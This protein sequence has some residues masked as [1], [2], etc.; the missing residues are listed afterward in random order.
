M[1]Q[2]IP[3]EIPMW[4][5]DSGEWLWK[6]LSPRLTRVT[7]AMED[8]LTMLALNW[9]PAVTART[10]HKGRAVCI[11]AFKQYFV[12]NDHET[13]SALVKARVEACHKYNVPVGDIASLEIAGILAALENTM[14]TAFWMLFYVFS[15]PSILADL[16][17]EL[18]NILQ[19]TEKSLGE[20]FRTLD[21]TAMKG[22]CPLL[23]SIF[24]ETLR[25]RSCGVSVRVV[26]QDTLLNDKFAIEA[27]CMIQMPSRVV[28][29]DPAI[30]GPTVKDFDPRRFLRGTTKEP[31]EHKAPAAAFR[32]FGGGTTLCPGR[33]FASTE[34]LCIVAMF[35]LR[36]DIDP[37]CGDWR[38]PPPKNQNIVA[39]TEF[40][41]VD[42]EVD[43]RPR[44]GYEDGSWGFQLGESQI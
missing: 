32:A 13:G 28:H 23:H 42:V 25:H 24:Q 4:K 22:K 2:R 15:S 5:M 33:H 34:V 12:I 29:D 1:V 21:V 26:L 18:E 44:E 38:M 14:P 11:E 10:G 8:D 20:T 37:V 39:S 17:F 35:A 30:W 7:R 19:T 9:L 27:G 36:Y 31:Q 16:R 40:P 6:F 3:S 41:G 43:V